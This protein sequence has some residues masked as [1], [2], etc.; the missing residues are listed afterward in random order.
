MAPRINVGAYGNAT[1]RANVGGKVTQVLQGVE[2]EIN[3]RKDRLAQEEERAYQKSERDRIAK[4]RVYQREEDF[5]VATDIPDAGLG[6][7][8]GLEETF[9]AQRDEYAAIAA[10]GADATPEERAKLRQFKANIGKVSAGQ[11]HLKTLLADYRTAMDT[12][13]AISASTPPGIAQILKDLDS[14]KGDFRPVNVDGEMRLQGKDSA[15]NTVDYSY[16][17]LT[18]LKFSPK[19][20]LNDALTEDVQQVGKIK[21]EITNEFGGSATHTNTPELVRDRVLQVAQDRLS[22]EHVLYEAGAELGW[23]AEARQAILDD[24]EQGPEAFRAL[25]E[26]A[27]ADR[28]TNSLDSVIT[29]D[30][31]QN[32]A[33]LDQAV[34]ASRS[35][36]GG[37]GSQGAI[38][39]G[40]YNTYGNNLLGGN[41]SFLNTSLQSA[42]GNDTVQTSIKGSVVSVT[43][44]ASDV[45]GAKI[46]LAQGK[47]LKLLDGT[48]VTANNINDFDDDQIAGAT[49]E[50]DSFD[51]N[52]PAGNRALF[53]QYERGQGYTPTQ[54]GGILP[55]ISGVQQGVGIQ[56]RNPDQPIPINEQVVTALAPAVPLSTDSSV[57]FNQLA[58]VD[59]PNTRTK[60]NAYIRAFTTLTGEVPYFLAGPD[61]GVN[62]DYKISGL[63]A[64]K[65][66]HTKIQN[67]LKAKL[68]ELNKINNTNYTIEDLIAI[69]QG[70]EPSSQNNTNQSNTQNNT[71]NGQQTYHN[72]LYTDN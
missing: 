43:A 17:Q 45:N 33:Q 22:N 14:G 46:A 53:Q 50:L 8:A 26:Q 65:A 28:L 34:A 20:K 31:V 15:G 62:P 69:S 61:G 27:Y 59:N 6:Y 29:T 70:R 44:V 25:V 7:E 12:D 55:S 36:S 56:G 54:L 9:K 19:Y 21:R 71:N 39:A 38:V 49:Y 32:Q 2:Q 51:V 10:K 72:F 48:V 11:N 23:N 41:T 13:G 57:K 58:T 64:D 18:S 1:D 52:T 40:D 5:Y 4:E 66:G 63:S 3:Q 24:P 37:T 67:A 68:D 16:D 30:G 42:Y 47:T 35:K 60:T